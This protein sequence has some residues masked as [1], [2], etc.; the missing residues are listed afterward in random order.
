MG[1]ISIGITQF[2][3]TLARARV[4]DLERLGAWSQRM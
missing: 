4:A 3:I 2:E 1:D